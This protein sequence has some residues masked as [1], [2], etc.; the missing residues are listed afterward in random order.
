M[1]MTVWVDENELE[2][3]NKEFPVDRYVYVIEYDID[4]RALK[5]SK[6]YKTLEEALKESIN[7]S[8]WGNCRI[9]K[10]DGRGK[11]V[12][13]QEAWKLRREYAL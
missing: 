8:S 2:K 12:E 7:Y 5:R 11:I 10:L 1:W 9:I 4:E 6:E 3:L 13:M